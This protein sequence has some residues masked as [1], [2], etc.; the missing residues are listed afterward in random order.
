[1]ATA[2]TARIRPDLEYPSG[3]GKPMAETSRH[4]QN[5]TDLIAVLSTWFAKDPQVYV[6]GNMLL[7]CVRGNPRLRVWPDVF[8]TRGIPRDKVRD[9][10][11]MWEEGKGPDVV[12]EL[13]S[14]STRRE[15]QVAKF[16]R[17]RDRLKV[18]EYFLFDPH[19]EYLDP[20]LA[21]YRL[22]RGTYW[23]IKPVR[24]R[25][26][27]N[28]LRL[29]LEEE[30]P[31]LRLHAPATGRRLPTPQEALAQREGELRQARAAQRRIK[32]ENEK[33]RREI[34]ALRRRVSRE[35]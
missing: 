6:S 28:V 27:S 18:R 12:I 30:G 8:V 19:G 11:L 13:T 7:Y 20:R 33:L 14:R 1:M 2:P 21:G 35:R 25:L 9:V 26:P 15:D 29:H 17:Y 10:Y 3:D 34:A 22:R 31:D 24:G 16:T 5:L 32:A 4:R 23:L